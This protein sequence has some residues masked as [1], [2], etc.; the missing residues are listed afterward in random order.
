MKCYKTVPIAL[1]STLLVDGYNLY[2]GLGRRCCNCLQFSRARYLDGSV[3][4]KKKRKELSC[5]SSFTTCLR[6]LCMAS[7][8]GNRMK[9][10][11]IIAL[12]RFASLCVN[13]G[14]VR[15]FSLCVPLG[16]VQHIHLLGLFL[17]CCG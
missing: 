16:F 13:S 10:F 9:K 7:Y 1:L 4:K 8:M 17:S 6:A 3:A 2:I 5:G 11:D 15:Y 12:H 14:L